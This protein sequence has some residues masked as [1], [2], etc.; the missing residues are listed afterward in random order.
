MQVGEREA[1]RE[2]CGEERGSGEGQRGWREGVGE[3]LEERV[4]TG[5]MRGE[6]KGP[7]DRGGSSESRP[8]TLRSVAR[9][10]SAEKRTLA[11]KGLGGEGLPW[12][13]FRRGGAGAAPAPSSS[14]I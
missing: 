5:P 13:G 11:G 4:V 14:R 9:A 6:C 8:R 3:G 1:S 10:G 12:G 2:S 7:G